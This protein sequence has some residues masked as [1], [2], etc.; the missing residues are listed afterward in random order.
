MPGGLD[1]DLRRLGIPHVDVESL[2]LL[3]QQEDR[4]TG[5]AQLVALGA[6]KT[7]SPPSQ[8]V[9]L[10]LVQTL[11]QVPL[12]SLERSQVS[13]NLS[14]HTVSERRSRGGGDLRRRR[15]LPTGRD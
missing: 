11:A 3:D 12:P 1:R 7:R 9:D 4:F 14:I 13:A 6:R 5:G 10:A 15:R 8:L 2:D